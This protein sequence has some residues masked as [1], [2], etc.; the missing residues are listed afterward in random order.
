MDRR[1]FLKGLFTVAAT[2]AVPKIIDIEEKHVDNPDGS[3]SIE[4][5]GAQIECVRCGK[6][7]QVPDINADVLKCSDCGVM[8]LLG[9]IRQRHDR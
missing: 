6:I 1:N 8:N 7:L 5:V 3:T 4:I 9:M 2:G